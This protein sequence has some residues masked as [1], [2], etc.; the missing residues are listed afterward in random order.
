MI[1]CP[2]EVFP[3]LYHVGYG[4]QGMCLGSPTVPEVECKQ[5][6]VSVL[7]SWAA[8]MVTGMVLQ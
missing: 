4:L 2:Q 8:G 1:P 3:P 6:Q 7:P 5:G